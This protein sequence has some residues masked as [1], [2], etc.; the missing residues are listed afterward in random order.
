MFIFKKNKK[1]NSI[2]QVKRYLTFYY[3]DLMYKQSFEQV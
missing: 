2:S 3:Y 1:T